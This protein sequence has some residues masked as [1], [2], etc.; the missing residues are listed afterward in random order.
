[1]NGG[2]PSGL[3][4]LGGSW[5]NGIQNAIAS[6]YDYYRH[7][8]AALADF[9]ANVILS[10][11]YSIYHAYNAIYQAAANSCGFFNPTNGFFSDHTQGL[12]ISAVFADESAALFGDGEGDVEA[13]SLESVPVEGAAPMGGFTESGATINH[14]VTLTAIG[15]DADTLQNFARSK[16]VNGHD[17][18]VHGDKAEFMI[19]GVT[20]HPQQIADAILSNPDYHGGPINLVS[21]GAACGSAQELSEILGVPVTAYSGRVDIDPTGGFLRELPW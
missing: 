12:V 7:E 9:P 3:C 10:T 18:I 8:T 17:V 6:T 19:D 11:G 5:C 4:F 14:S 2:D 20:T 21:C 15:D 1:V 13:I 16:G